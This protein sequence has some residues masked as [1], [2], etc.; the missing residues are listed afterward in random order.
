MKKYKKAPNPDKPL[1][2]AEFNSMKTIY[3]LDGLAEIMGEEFVIPLRKRGRP[4]IVEPKEHVNL[5]LDAR[6]VEH[7]R[8]TGKGWQTRLNDFLSKSVEQGLV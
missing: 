8:T 4:K 7:F 2:D 5:R 1:T 3:G 6:L